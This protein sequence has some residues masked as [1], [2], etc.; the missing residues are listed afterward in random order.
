[1]KTRG[2][3]P[4]FGRI[5][6]IDPMLGI[7]SRL[8]DT[9]ATSRWVNNLKLALRWVAAASVAGGLA[10]GMEPIFRFTMRPGPLAIT[11]AVEPSLSFAV[12]ANEG[13]RERRKI[14]SSNMQFRKTAE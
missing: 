7:L 9:H 3:Y 13:R 14:R 11:R 1:L 2:A 5:A 4:V 6:Q 8:R 12:Q 10:S